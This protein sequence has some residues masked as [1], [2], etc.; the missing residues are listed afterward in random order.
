MTL[1]KRILIYIVCC[2]GLFLA[3]MM[4]AGQKYH[5]AAIRMQREVDYNSA[6]AKKIAIEAQLRVAQAHLKAL[7]EVG[8]KAADK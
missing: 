8:K 2:S 4:A 1:G 6:L 5:D 3:F 7:Q